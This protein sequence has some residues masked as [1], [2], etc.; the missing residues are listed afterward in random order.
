M[1]FG[2]LRLL[3]LCLPADLDAHQATAPYLRFRQQEEGWPR[4][5]AEARQAKVDAILASRRAEKA[6]AEAAAAAAAAEAAEAEAAEAGAAEAGAAEPE[7]AAQHEEKA[8]AESFAQ[9]EEEKV[10]VPFIP[11]DCEEVSFLSLPLGFGTGLLPSGS[12]LVP[13]STAPGRYVLEIADDV[14]EAALLPA[15]ITASSSA[16][17]ATSSAAAVAGPSAPELVAAQIRVVRRVPT[18]QAIEFVVTVPETV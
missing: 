18:Y 3:G 2:G 9:E 16:S 8:E 13:S 4:R 17:T 5:K 14:A 7:P 11:E 1:F 15:D 12:L 10:E 6:A